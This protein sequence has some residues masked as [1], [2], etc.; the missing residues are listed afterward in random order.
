MHQIAAALSEGLLRNQMAAEIG[1]VV[2][3]HY[4]WYILVG[5]AAPASH[6]Q[7]A[8][9]PDCCP[10]RDCRV[11]LASEVVATS[12]GYHIVDLDVVVSA[13]DPRVRMS[14]DS[15]FYICSRPDIAPSLPASL[16]T[17]SLETP[18]LKCLL[19]PAMS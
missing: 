11:G 12:N 4:L 1:V 5:L 2:M 10:E 14:T 16:F 3:K 6:A 19:V 15:R 7:S 17:L 9:S 8:I 13:D 18:I